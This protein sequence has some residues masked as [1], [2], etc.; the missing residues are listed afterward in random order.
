MSGNKH[1][2]LFLGVAALLF[3]INAVTSFGHWWF[4]YPLVSVG[5]AVYLHWLRVSFF[6]PEKAKQMRRQLLQ[7]ELSRLDEKLRDNQD[8]I[9][10]AEKQV[11]ERIHFYNHFYIYVGVNAFLILINLLTSPFNWWFHFPLLG[12]GIGIFFHWLKL[13]I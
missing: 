3:L 5:L 6:S 7:K 8:V 9:E 12:W 4:Q 13:K 11:N 1:L 10:K 2:R